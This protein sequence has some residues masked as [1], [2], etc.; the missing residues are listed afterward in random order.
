MNRR[1]LLK[2]LLTSPLA[3]AIDYEKLLWVP[4]PIIVVPELPK[5]VAANWLRPGRG[6]IQVLLDAADLREILRTG[7]MDRMITRKVVVQYAR[8]DY[9]TAIQARLLNED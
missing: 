5:F 8:Q 2:L 4:K 3:A 9:S 7:K 1:D 6:N